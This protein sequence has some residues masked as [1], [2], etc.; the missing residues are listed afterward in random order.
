DPL[1]MHSHTSSEY[2]QRH[3]STGH[4]DPR[5]GDD[6]DPPDNAR[7]FYITGAPHGVGVPG[8]D[9]IGEGEVNGMTPG[10]VLRALLV[11]MDR[12]ATDGT[13]PPESVLPKRA[14]GTL[15]KPDEV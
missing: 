5:D 10:P 14:D 7:M 12:W 1:V 9:W 2:W 8:A 3:G 6:I 11:L 13:Q 4:T 15:V